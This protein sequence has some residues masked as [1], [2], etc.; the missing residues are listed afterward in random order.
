MAPPADEPKWRAGSDSRMAVYLGDF[1]AAHEHLTEYKR[2]MGPDLIEHTLAAERALMI[3]YETGRAD[4][5]ANEA[6]AFLDVRDTL[7]GPRTEEDSALPAYE[8]APM[9]NALKRAGRLTKAEVHAERD[10]FIADWK[11][12]LGPDYQP[13]LWLIT[14]AKLAEDEADAREALEVLPRF[15]GTPK[16]FDNL[17]DE[18]S[19]G[20]V[21]LLAGRSDEAIPWFSQEAHACRLEDPRVVWAN[22]ELGK[23]LEQ[24]GE[25]DKA[26][27]GYAFVLKRWGN[28]KPKSVTADEAKKRSK[29]LGC[30]R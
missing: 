9:L 6:R 12:R 15:N 5:G 23:A 18:L 22:L 13:Y 30:G 3:A 26:C 28:A 19:I 17:P 4:E 20:R 14:Y 8:V 11:P 29:A 25:K 1:A 7:T 27:D 16:M 2:L 21:Y 10:R 24:K